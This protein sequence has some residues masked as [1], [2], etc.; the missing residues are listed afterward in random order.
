MDI[1]YIFDS[2]DSLKYGLKRL[3]SFKKSVWEFKNIAEGT[4]AVTIIPH[5]FGPGKTSLGKKLGVD[6]YLTLSRDA[7]LVEIQNGSVIPYFNLLLSNHKLQKLPKSRL[8][9]ILFTYSLPPEL[10]PDNVGWAIGSDAHLPAKQNVFG[11]AKVEEGS[12]FDW[13]DFLK[14]QACLQSLYYEEITKLQIQK[15]MRATFHDYLFK[16]YKLLTKKMR[17]NASLR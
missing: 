5:P 6:N 4:N 1:I 14:N 7:D 12:S 2:E 10:R 17:Y 3:K 16:K 15:F 13:F 11:Q 9:E 8:D